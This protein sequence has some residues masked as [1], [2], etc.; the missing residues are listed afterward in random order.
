MTA[1][2][3]LG[4]KGIKDTIYIPDANPDLPGGW[5]RGGLSKLLDE[6]ADSIR[7]DALNEAG[8][9][10]GKDAERFIKQHGEGFKSR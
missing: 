1:K 5:R 2:E 3:F 10:T 8:I 7:D 4:S 9:L 6:Y